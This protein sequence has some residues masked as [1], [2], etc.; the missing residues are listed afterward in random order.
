MNQNTGENNV[1]YKYSL[2][3]ES[4]SKYCKTN[5]IKDIYNY[6]TI[7]ILHYS[8]DVWSNYPRKLPRGLVNLTISNSIVD[9]ELDLPRRVKELRI[10]NSIVTGDINYIQN[11]DVLHVNNGIAK[12]HN[13]NTKMTTNN[14]FITD[15]NDKSSK[16]HVVNKV[17]KV[18][19]SIS[20]E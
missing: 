10:N 3:D 2:D 1:I 12:C 19:D 20:S 6:E 13:G 8:N 18:D 15:Q 17:N 9:T 16:G 4:T 7:K 5:E 14:T 11:L